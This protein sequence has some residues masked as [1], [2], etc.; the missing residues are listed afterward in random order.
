[1][2]TAIWAKTR[3]M[4]RHLNSSRIQAI[5]VLLV[6]LLAILAAFL[7]IAIGLA[8]HEG[9]SW[10]GFFQDIVQ[11]AFIATIVAAVSA[12]INRLALR[13]EHE[14]L[15]SRTLRMIL[16]ALY[17][18]I[19][20]IFEVSPQFKASRAV[21]MIDNT[22]K[23]LRQTSSALIDFN[24]KYVS[25]PASEKIYSDPSA[26]ALQEMLNA[27]KD[28]IGQFDKL[29]TWS[30]VSKHI[31]LSYGYQG[32]RSQR[33]IVLSYIVDDL[34]QIAT[35]GGALAGSAIVARDRAVMYV[36]LVEQ[37]DATI[38]SDFALGRSLALAAG[39]A[40]NA[41]PGVDMAAFSSTSD[42]VAYL[43]AYCNGLLEDAATERQIRD[44]VTPVSLSLTALAQELAAAAMLAHAMSNLAQQA[45]SLPTARRSLHIY[46]E[47]ADG[48]EASDSAMTVNA[49]QATGSAK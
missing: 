5:G 37:T 46:P 26:R 49:G 8:N 4:L 45:L 21:Q 20:D 27:M 33:R 38:E 29:I 47:E 43:M 11:F 10:V 24:N 13:R 17:G 42:R 36:A 41:I 30:E 6:S 31:A 19:A 48:G 16:V 23:S 35:A 9:W 39:T 12:A 32:L 34:A 22:E 7:K 18:N 2:N 1:M 40:R 3:G 28:L 44:V 14:A 15:V 25:P